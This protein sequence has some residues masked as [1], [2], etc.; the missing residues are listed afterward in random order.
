MISLT[1]QQKKDLM[2]SPAMKDLKRKYDAKMKGNGVRRMKGMGWW[3]TVGRAIGANAKVIFDNIGK[4]AKKGYEID[5]FLR[6]SK[7]ISKVADGVEKGA[8]GLTAFQPELIE[9]TAPVAA[10]A[11]LVKD[12][13]KSIGYGKGK[14]VHMKGMG[15]STS[16]RPYTAK[17][18]GVITKLPTIVPR[19]TITHNGIIASTSV[20]SNVSSINKKMSGSGKNT[21]FHR[22]SDGSMMKGKVHIGRGVPVGTFGSISGNYG[23]TVGL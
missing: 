10:A 7:I 22:M 6:Q 3:D 14:R 9:F 21:N 11:E 4:T 8:I 15:R 12:G 20:P 1:P 19:P 5:K 16:V 17:P 13:A 23:K 2:K 18:K